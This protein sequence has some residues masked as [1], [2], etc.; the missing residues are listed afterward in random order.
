[1]VGLDAQAASLEWIGMPVKA[2]FRRL[3]TFRPTD[4]YFVPIGT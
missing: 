3:A 2:K 4:V 1:V